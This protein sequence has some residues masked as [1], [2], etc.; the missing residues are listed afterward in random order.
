MFGEDSDFGYGAGVMV[1]YD[2]RWVCF[3]TNLS[4]MVG[5]KPRGSFMATVPE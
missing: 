5:K 3:V 4:I 1:L 2:S